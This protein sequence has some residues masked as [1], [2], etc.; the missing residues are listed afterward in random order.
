MM[1]I[2]TKLKVAWKENFIRHLRNGKP[3]SEA[4]IFA[5]VGLEKLNLARKTD[6]EFDSRIKEAKEKSLPAPSW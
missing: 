5:G 1:Q 6:P 3:L 2:N 4:A